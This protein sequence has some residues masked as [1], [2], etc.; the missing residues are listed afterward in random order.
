MNFTITSFFSKTGI[1]SSTVKIKPGRSI[2]TMDHVD[3][4]VYI[5]R[6]TLREN[7]RPFLKKLVSSGQVKKWDRADCERC[8]RLTQVSAIT[9]QCRDCGVDLSQWADILSVRLES[10]EEKE[11][12]KKMAKLFFMEKTLEMEPELKKLDY[13]LTMDDKHAFDDSEGEDEDYLYK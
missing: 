4:P 13:Q 2:T 7:G 1:T 5:G 12:K 11:K 3:L 8:G 6:K 10:L 9:G